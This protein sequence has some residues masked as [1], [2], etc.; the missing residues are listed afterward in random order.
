M[1]QSEVEILTSGPL[2]AR[3]IEKVG[4]GRLYPK[5][6]KRYAAADQSGRAYLVQRAVADVG[7]ALAVQTTPKSNV[8][9]LS[10]EHPDAQVAAAVLNAH[11]TGYLQYRREVLSDVTL[12]L[13]SQ[14]RR[15][16]ETRL[17]QANTQLKD[18]LASEKIGDFVSE[19]VSLGTLEATLRE[20]RYRVQARLRE[21]EGR[22]GGLNRAPVA[23]QIDLYRDVDNTAENRLRDLRIQREELLSR[24]KPNAR[25]VQEVEVQVAQL[26][27]M[28]REGRASPP[29]RAARA[30]P[31]L[32]DGGDRPDPAP[33]RS[34]VAGQPPRRA[35]RPARGGER[36]PH[37]LHPHRAAVRGTGAPAR[38]A[39]SQPARL[40]QPRT[41]A[42]GRPGDRPGG[43]RQHPRRAACAAAGQGVEPPRRA[44]DRGL[45]VRR[46]DRVRGGARPDLP[47]PQ[48]PDAASASRTLDLPVLATASFKGAPA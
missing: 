45:P 26:E 42:A 17:A 14:Q 12:P 22:L 10:Y 2:T 24:Y 20:E 46:H 31:D 34:G 44:A 40:P 13:V 30:E 21:V 38:H 4:Y 39:G 1:T 47:A 9:R 16:F 37:A 48:L 27:R 8:I 5:N 7:A 18:F 6:A 25:P 15:V 43:H 3:T 35:R 28:L 23:A 19:K 41:G 29:A 11:V 36:A 32:P 33:R